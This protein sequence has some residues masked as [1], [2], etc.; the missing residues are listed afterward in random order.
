MSCWMRTSDY[1]IFTFADEKLIRLTF[2]ELERE[3]TIKST[4]SETILSEKIS[5]MSQYELSM[6]FKRSELLHIHFIGL[7]SKLLTHFNLRQ[8]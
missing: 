7:F 5:T 6:L 3:T 2:P 8:S 4:S 1:G